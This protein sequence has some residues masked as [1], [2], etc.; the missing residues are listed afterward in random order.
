MERLTVITRNFILGDNNPYYM[1]GP[2]ISAVGGPHI[3]PRRR[4]RWLQLGALTTFRSSLQLVEVL[5]DRRRR[6]R[7]RSRARL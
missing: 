4:G 2:V 1:H 7:M 3:G 5:D 6:S